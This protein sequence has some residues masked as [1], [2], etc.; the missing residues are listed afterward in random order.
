MKSTHD[1]TVH[2]RIVAR[3]EQLW[4]LTLRSCCRLDMKIPWAVTCPHNEAASHRFCVVGRLH[5]CITAP[6]LDRVCL[7]SDHLAET[8]FWPSF[9]ALP[10]PDLLFV[11]I[12]HLTC[13]S[14]ICPSPCPSSSPVRSSPC[15]G[16]RNNLAYSTK[17]QS[18][19]LARPS[20]TW[21]T[22]SRFALS[23]HDNPAIPDFR[24]LLHLFSDIHL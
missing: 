19:T 2:V 6:R 12:G 9:L 14:R 7:T 10:L 13:L 1:G 8:T 5:S 24:P 11:L 17:P 20:S 22:T 18:S 16:E 21:T 4:W 15:F 3:L 23:T